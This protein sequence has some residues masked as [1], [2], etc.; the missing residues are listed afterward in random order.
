MK[1]ILLILVFLVAG[2]ASGY[3]A[4]TVK[5]QRPTTDTMKSPVVVSSVPNSGTSVQVKQVNAQ[6]AVVKVDENDCQVAGGIHRI[7]GWSLIIIIL[8]I[9]FT[10]AINSNLLRASITDPAAFLSAAKATRK[11]ATE[12]D[13]SKIPKPF[14]LSRSQLGAWTIVISCS[15]IYLELCKYVPTQQIPIDNTLL[16]LMGISAGTA[17]AS[18][19]IDTNSSPEQ[20]GLQAPSQGFLK[21]ILSDQNG[22]NIH[23]FQNVV[24]TMIAIVLYISQIPHL[25]CG[26]LPT[27]DNTLIALTGISSATYLGLK[28]N[29]NKPPA[30]PHGDDPTNPVVPTPPPAPV[31]PVAPPVPPVVVPPVAPVAA[32][33]PPPP[34]AT[35]VVPP[36]DPTV[37]TTPP[38]TPGT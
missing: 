21:D 14:S 4:D 1:K 22:I 26:E 12:A 17:A 32:V 30:L 36:A 27:L 19:V 20:Q 16:A 24:W 5:V 37:P 11:H 8:V 9:F 29:E 31:V 18:N 2:L 15:Y 34:V 35:P 6:T 7:V 25:P 28:I 33:V 23:R 10:I 38:T 13:I 3:A